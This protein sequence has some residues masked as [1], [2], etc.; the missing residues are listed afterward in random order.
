MADFRV[1][2]PPQYP[3]PTE[4]RTAIADEL[5]EK[6]AVILEASLERCEITMKARP[7]YCG[8]V[9]SSLFLSYYRL[10]RNENVRDLFATMSYHSE[11]E[12]LFYCR[13]TIILNEEDACL[14]ILKE[15]GLIE[16]TLFRVI[17]LNNTKISVALRHIYTRSLIDR[18]ILAAAV[19]ANKKNMVSLS[20]AMGFQ[21]ADRDASRPTDKGVR[22][23]S[24]RE[25][26]Q[27]LSDS[28]DVYFT[29]V[30]LMWKCHKLPIS[31]CFY[32]PDKPKN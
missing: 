30:E 1:V 24:D 3:V 26:L 19:V 9:K 27:L 17:D 29:W 13:A 31:A 28:R 4:A 23:L 12:I 14:A 8:S 22:V 5:F 15:K 16:S 7:N 18:G 21:E 32:N 11:E 10:G 25:V 20:N 6:A 2:S